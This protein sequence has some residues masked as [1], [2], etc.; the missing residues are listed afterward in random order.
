MKS[1]GNLTAEENAIM[2][3]AMAD[4]NGGEATDYDEREYDTT[5]DQLEDYS[6]GNS[7]VEYASLRGFEVAGYSAVEITG[8]QVR[9]G[10]RRVTVLVVDFG[11]VRAIKK[12]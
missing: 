9:K 1:A 11:R 5:L 3:E 12:G 4:A 10:E 6:G 7:L 8:A 2:L